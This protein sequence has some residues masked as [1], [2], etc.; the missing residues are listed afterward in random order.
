MM[1]CEQGRSFVWLHRCA[2]ISVRTCAQALSLSLSL[3]QPPIHRVMCLSH[4]HL[5]CIW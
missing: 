3:Q 1:L 4:T 2:R 5:V